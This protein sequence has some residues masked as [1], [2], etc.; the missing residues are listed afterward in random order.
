MESVNEPGATERRVQGRPIKAQS[1]AG[2]V[3]PASICNAERAPLDVTSG[4]GRLIH[5]FPNP[6]DADRR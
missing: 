1:T 4:R 5:G 2:M 6:I 3:S